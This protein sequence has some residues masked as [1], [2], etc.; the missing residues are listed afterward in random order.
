MQLRAPLS[1]RSLLYS[2]VN[3]FLDR[4]YVISDTG[5]H[6]YPDRNQKQNLQPNP[7]AF[8][9]ERVG[10]HKCQIGSTPPGPRWRQRSS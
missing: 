10:N 5:L 9:G 2:M 3:Q 8:F 4:P 1:S 6:H 7:F